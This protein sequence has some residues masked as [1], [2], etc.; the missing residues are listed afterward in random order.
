MNDAIR[1][2]DIVKVQSIIANINESLN[3]KSIDLLKFAYSSGKTDLL[4][5]LIHAGADINKLDNKGQTILYYL[6]GHAHKEKNH[7][8]LIDFLLQ[9]NADITILNK[10]ATRTGESETVL[11]SAFN[12]HR[13][14]FVEKILKHGKTENIYSKSYQQYYRLISCII[15][16]DMDEFKRV[17]KDT[18][19]KDFSNLNEENLLYFAISEKNTEC[20][21][22]LL[23]C[24]IDVNHNI[25]ESLI[26]HAID[27]YQ[28][29]VMEILRLFL[30]FNYKGFEKLQRIPGMSIRIWSPLSYAASLP[31]LTDVV[32]F[33]LEDVKVNV[34]A[35]DKNN[36]TA[37]YNVSDY[38]C[39]SSIELM[40]KHNANPNCV[41]KFHNSTPLHAAAGYG[42][43][44]TIKLL[45]EYG[46]DIKALDKD[47]RTVL[48]YAA[49]NR[50]SSL[51]L[52]YFLDMK[53]FDVNCQDLSGNTPLHG[54]DAEDDY[55]LWWSYADETPNR[56]SR[57]SICD[58]YLILLQS[59]ANENIEN[60]AKRYPCCSSSA[61]TY[62]N[63]PVLDYFIKLRLLN[64]EVNEK[65]WKFY[66]EEH[67]QQNF[68]KEDEKSQL[69]NKEIDDL[70]TIIISPF[71]RRITLYDILF[72]KSHM[73]VKYLN[74][75]VLLDIY[76]KFKHFEKQFL[77][78]G[79]FLKK[80]YEEGLVRKDLQEAVEEMLYDALGKVLPAI[81][82]D[83]IFQYFSYSQ[84]KILSDKGISNIN[85]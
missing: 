76:H 35:A 27:V 32:R 58:N 17:L 16:D 57:G 38:D 65:I 6:I 75:V 61:N 13:Y 66:L 41:E 21:R 49:E 15:S 26:H 42:D 44:E 5:I 53:I 45:V 55:E 50:R 12:S 37:L 11:H 83:E 84:L 70:K 74:N 25:K 36:Y 48:H 54:T 4:E 78:Y 10:R 40:L 31:E 30:D 24:G 1:Q 68:E 2:N 67:G 63:C 85:N 69:F 8:N 23:K 19:L 82:Y 22:Q 3:E 71:P 52:K 7:N 64:Y 81:C 59:G 34:N 60:L 18:N 72:M 56:I 29:D 77:H 80:K 62:N 33:L 28:K 9:H 14:G 43:L 20:V 51:P 73:L 47:G 79:D 46:S 39:M